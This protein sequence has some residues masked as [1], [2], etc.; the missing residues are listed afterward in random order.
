MS[1][2]AGVQPFEGD[3]R[4]ELALEKAWRR[5][6][7]FRAGSGSYTPTYPSTSQAVYGD[8]FL[9]I[10]YKNKVK[11]CINEGSPSSRRR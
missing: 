1:Q 11:D 6:T 5:Y 8:V 2:A 9:T 4:Y 10:D 7:R 3:A